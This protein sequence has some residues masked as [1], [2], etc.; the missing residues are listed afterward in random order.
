M[1]PVISDMAPEGDGFRF[2]P[3]RWSTAIMMKLPEALG[4][5]GQ[6]K[7]VLTEPEENSTGLFPDV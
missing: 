1:I 7:S 6:R 3:V 4:S 5:L 2:P